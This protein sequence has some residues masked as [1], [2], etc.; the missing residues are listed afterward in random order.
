[1][2]HM[3]RYAMLRCRFFWHWA[4]RPVGVMLDL[5]QRVWRTR[6]PVWRV[7]P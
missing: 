2:L 6:L 4:L 3:A 5:L 7:T 1:M